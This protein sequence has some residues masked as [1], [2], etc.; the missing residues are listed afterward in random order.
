MKHARSALLAALLV[1]SLAGGAYAQAGGYILSWHTVDGGGGPLP[2]GPYSLN[3]TIGQADAGASSGGGYA[4]VG[5]FWGGA[6]AALGKLY[7]PVV[8]RVQ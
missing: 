6:P 4:L 5:G 2:S 3:G 1:L 7:L 8:V